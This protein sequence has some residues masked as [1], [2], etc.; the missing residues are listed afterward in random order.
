[1]SLPIGGMIFKGF[2]KIRAIC[3]NRHLQ[4][5]L[6]LQQNKKAVKLIVEHP[7]HMYV[8]ETVNI[9]LCEWGRYSFL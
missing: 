8:S 9:L 5:L 2:R 6:Q 3:I 1:M 4:Q 7:I